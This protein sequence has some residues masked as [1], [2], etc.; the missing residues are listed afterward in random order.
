MKY[1][2]D[3]DANKAAI[4]Q[5]NPNDT[6]NFSCHSGLP[7]FNTCCHNLNLFLYPYDVVRLKK[8]L[9]LSTDEII[10][11]YVD[12]VLREGQ[13]FPEVMLRMAE[14]PEKPCIFLRSEGCGVYGDRPHTCRL[15]P[16]EQGAYVNAATGRAQTVNFFRPPGFCQG[17]AQEQV[18]TVDAYTR[19]QG[20]QTY[21]EMTTRWAEIRGLMQTNPWG[22]EGPEGAR[23]KMAFMAAYNIDRFREF[24]FESSFLKRYRISGKVKTKIRK[25]DTELLR[26]GFAWIQLFLWGKLSTL[27]RP[28]T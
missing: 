22:N 16:I 17:P 12:I 1:L 18:N 19:G 26:L 4:N 23:A 7:C 14:T 21:V 15:F 6:F 11:N 10:H 27:I 24:V 8:G 2:S 13:F 20:A 3:L 9:G 25:S 28:M 5:L